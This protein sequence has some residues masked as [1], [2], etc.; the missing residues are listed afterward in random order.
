G[1]IA[2]GA[3]G[4]AVGGKGSKASASTE[5]LKVPE[6]LRFLRDSMVATA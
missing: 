4:K 5:D 2:A 6:G 1:Y 3:V